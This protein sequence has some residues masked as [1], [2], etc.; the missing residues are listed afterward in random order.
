MDPVVPYKSTAGSSNF[1]SSSEP[2]N[3]LFVRIYNACNCIWHEL[4]VCFIKHRYSAITFL[5]I[6]PLAFIANNY[7]LLCLPGILFT[8]VICNG[9]IRFKKREYLAESITNHRKAL[10]QLKKIHQNFDVKKINTKINESRSL[11][12][13]KKNLQ[14]VIDTVGKYDTLLSR[15]REFAFCNVG[16]AKE[17][18]KILLRSIDV[19][20]SIE[21]LPEFKDS[22]TTYIHQLHKSL[23]EV[24]NIKLPAYIKLLSGI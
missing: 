6:I 2:R 20:P 15:N 5:A 23:A 7:K 21:H 10:D 11:D 14:L 19:Y 16:K 24:V 1:H 4:K 3:E 12:Q 22:I 9:F 8:I 17:H 18:L 13:L